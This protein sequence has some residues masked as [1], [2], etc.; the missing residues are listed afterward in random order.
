MCVPPSHFQSLDLIRAPSTAGTAA[1]ERVHK[2][3]RT[4][5][6][7]VSIVIK[8]L[9]WFRLSLSMRQ[10]FLCFLSF[11]EAALLQADHFLVSSREAAAEDGLSVRGHISFQRREASEDVAELARNYHVLN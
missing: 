11:L 8:E 1:E 6:F 2:R 10:K 4:K 7:I 9:L 5:D 3:P